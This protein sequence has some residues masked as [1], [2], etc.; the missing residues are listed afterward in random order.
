MTLN[1]LFPYLFTAGGGLI[2]WWVR[3][4]ETEQA[5]LRADVH[6]ATTTLAVVTSEYAGVRAQIAE[7]KELISVMTERV[8]RV[9]YN[10]AACSR[11]SSDHK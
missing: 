9:L 6:Q 3:N 1:E 4:I 5:K 10:M 11:D 8:D 7:V 2:A